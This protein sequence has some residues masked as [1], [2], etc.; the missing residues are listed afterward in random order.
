M[1]LATMSYQQIRTAFGEL[2][3]VTDTPLEHEAALPVPTLRWERPLF[4]GFAGPARRR[5]GQPIEFGTPDRWWTVDA[6][7]GRLVSF[8]LTSFQPFPGELAAGPVSRPR[9]GRSAAAAKE[10]LDQLTARMQPAAAAFFAGAAADPGAGL[11]EAIRAHL[12]TGE[13][14]W[15]RALAPDFFHW[16]EATS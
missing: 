16:L 9:T 2:K 12:S 1:T 11:S 7:H 13:L 3:R 4:A 15:Y 5:P 10:A 8:N 14:R 6:T